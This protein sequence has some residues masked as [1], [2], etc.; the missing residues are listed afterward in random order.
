MFSEGIKKTSRKEWV[1]DAEIDFFIKIQ[2]YAKQSFRYTYFSNT[3]LILLKLFKRKNQT[4][5]NDL[6][7]IELN[8]KNCCQS[9]LLTVFLATSTKLKKEADKKCT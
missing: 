7:P 4:A 9:T 6:V 1:T 5:T 2:V 8:Y 3:F